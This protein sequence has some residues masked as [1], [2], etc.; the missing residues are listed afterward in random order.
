M[1]YLDYNASTPCAPEVVEAMLPYFSERF[2]NASATTYSMAWQC[3]EAVKRARNNIATHLNVSP[4]EILFT[5]GATESINMALKGL[6]ELYSS[7]AVINDAPLHIITSSTEHSAVLMTCD[8]LSKYKNVTVTYLPVDQHGIIKVQ[9]FENAIQPG[10]FLAIFALAN[11]ETGVIQPLETIASLCKERKILLFSDTTQAVG[12]IQVDPKK[13]GIDI[14]CMSG[15]KLYGPKG[16]G[17][18]YISQKNPR[19]RLNPL[20]HGGK[21]E[22]SWRAGTLNVPGIVGMGKAVEMIDINTF[23]QLA[24]WRD[25]LENAL[26][27]HFSMLINGHG[28]PRL[29][30]VSNISIE[31][32]RASELIK[33]IHHEL[34]ISLGSAC[35]AGS[36]KPSHVLTAMQVPINFIDGSIRISLGKY[37][38][39]KEISITIDL[40]KQHITTI[41]NNNL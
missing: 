22:D 12:K 36:N 9:D 2:A 24:T 8:Y 33:N 27:Q 31:G 34:G 14:A 17:A 26:A 37:T 35:N 11:N 5:S 32:I 10:T 23:Q 4:K 19:V 38:T 13:I 16:I 40:L 21:Q 18:L 20:H 6:Y 15:H 39:F 25:E 29:A 28:A 3:D 7:T 1:I 30:N 41:L